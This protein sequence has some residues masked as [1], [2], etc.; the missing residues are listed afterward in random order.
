[1]YFAVMPPVGTRNLVLI[2]RFSCT[3]DC[4][5][6]LF[7]NAQVCPACAASLTEPDDVVVSSSLNLLFWKLII[8]K[9]LC[10]AAHE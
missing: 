2:T 1:M 3:V 5:N 8:F 10:F 6:S 7:G 9:G 4:A